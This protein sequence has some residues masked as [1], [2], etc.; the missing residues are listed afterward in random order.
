MVACSGL[1]VRRV[2]RVVLRDAVGVHHSDDAAALVHQQ[3]VLGVAP[4]SRVRDQNA[5]S[6]KPTALGLRRRRRP[7]GSTMG[8]GRSLMNSGPAGEDSAD[9]GHRSVWPTSRSEV[10]RPPKSSRLTKIVLCSLAILFLATVVLLT[11]AVVR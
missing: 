3:V 1:P 4:A 2:V 7:F 10:V 11:L 8:V 5:G 9:I 6:G